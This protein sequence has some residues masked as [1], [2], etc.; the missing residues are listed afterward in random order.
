MTELLRRAA[1]DVLTYLDHDEWEPAL[2]VLGV[3]EAACGHG[4]AAVPAVHVVPQAGVVRPLWDVGGGDVGRVDTLAP[5]TVITMHEGRPVTGT[6]T[7]I[8]YGCV[9]ET[10]PRDR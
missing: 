8:E 5:E 1:E 10:R 7:V 4:G 2:D 6:A 9:G 3:L